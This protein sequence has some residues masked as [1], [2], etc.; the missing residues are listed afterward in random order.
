MPTFDKQEPIDLEAI[1]ERQVTALYWA[2]VGAAKPEIVKALRDT[3]ALLSEV[4][5][6]RAENA[7]LKDVLTELTYCDASPRPNA[8]LYATRRATA[9][10]A[11]AEEKP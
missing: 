6:L 5:R 4:D 7:E 9:A 2:G 8:R 1:R 10:L 3:D 11:K